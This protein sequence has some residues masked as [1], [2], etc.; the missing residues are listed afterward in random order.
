[1]QH[2]HDGQVVQEW[3]LQHLSARAGEASYQRGTSQLLVGPVVQLGQLEVQPQSRR[4]ATRVPHT[5]SKPSD[6]NNTRIRGHERTLDAAAP[7][8][9]TTFEYVC[10][11]QA[12]T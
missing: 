6:I 1:M 5:Y 3:V 8:R 7:L 9:T 10:S 2:F 4:H 11:H 12:D